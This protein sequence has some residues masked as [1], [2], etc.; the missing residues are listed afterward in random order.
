MISER[1]G[2]VLDYMCV[3]VRILQGQN[4]SSKRLLCFYLVTASFQLLAFKNR[5]VNSQHMHWSDQVPVT[6]TVRIPRS[7]SVA[8]MQTDGVGAVA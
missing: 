4:C 1:P 7:S 5:S 8:S 2:F 6:P 3:F